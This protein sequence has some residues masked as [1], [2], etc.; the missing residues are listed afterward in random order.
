[1]FSRLSFTLILWSVLV[2]PATSN[3][4]KPLV[5]HHVVT[6]EPDRQ[7]RRVAVQQFVRQHGHAQ[8]QLVFWPVED[9][10]KTTEPRL[11][12]TIPKQFPA[13]VQT[14]KRQYYQKALQLATQ[15]PPN[16]Q[17][18]G[19]SR[20]A[21]GAHVRTSLAF[22]Q[23]GHPLDGL[24]IG[25]DEPK[26]LHQSVLL[27]SSGSALEPA[28]SLDFIEEVFGLFLRDSGLVPGSS[29][30]VYVVGRTR[31]ETMPL[32]TYIID[33][34]PLG[35]RFLTGL[36][37]GT[38]VKTLHLPPDRK[39]ASAI[40]ESIHYL[41]SEVSEYP[42]RYQLVILSD[43]RQV[44]TGQWHFESYTPP[45]QRFLADLKSRKLLPDLR[46]WA[47]VA[48][49]HQRAKSNGDRFSAQDDSQLRTLWEEVFRAAGTQCQIFRTPESALYTL[50]HAFPVGTPTAAVP[51]TTTN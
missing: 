36:Q 41:V 49:A 47:V 11:T 48:V 24:V 38:E 34:T 40:A 20:L 44:T 32:W 27:D 22:H 45:P 12:I 30:R 26:P 7:S 14:K 25:T 31:A 21:T 33:D 13:P 5:Q 1:M 51:D 35:H 15:L 19:A 43:L 50:K 29:F 2:T 17:Y 6:T 16:P 28:V 8:N 4:H 10:A 39:H 46:H 37:A 3:D 42:G 23:A 18:I 9:T